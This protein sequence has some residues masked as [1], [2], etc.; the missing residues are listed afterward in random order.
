MFSVFRLGGPSVEADQRALAQ[1]G[2]GV[3]TWSRTARPPP[4]PRHRGGSNPSDRCGP[5]YRIGRTAPGCV[6]RPRY[7]EARDPLVS[8]QDAESI[9]D[10]GRKHDPVS[11]A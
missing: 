9:L 3:L 2:T 11:L 8:L 5:V 6:C 10:A 7:L 1:W 4:N